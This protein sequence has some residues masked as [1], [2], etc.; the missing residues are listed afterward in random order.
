VLT[1]F[2]AYLGAALIAYFVLLGHGL[3]S[4]AIALLIQQLVVLAVMMYLTVGRL[5][6]LKNLLKRYIPK[7][8]WPTLSKKTSE[9]ALGRAS[10]RAQF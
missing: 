10:I 2:N 1:F 8:F 5:V 4:A 9:T 7:E 3:E 6:L